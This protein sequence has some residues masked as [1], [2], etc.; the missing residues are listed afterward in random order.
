[1]IKFITKK[2]GP[3]S[4][5]NLGSLVSD[6]EKERSTRKQQSV[7][8]IDLASEICTNLYGNSVG[9]HS[10]EIG[11]SSPSY[12]S[13]SWLDMVEG[14]LKRRIQLKIKLVV[15]SQKQSKASEAQAL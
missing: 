6:H 13:L 12:S 9:K 7:S 8:F 2:R 14:K 3:S 11:E 15:Q 4:Q 1:M 5:E 10:K